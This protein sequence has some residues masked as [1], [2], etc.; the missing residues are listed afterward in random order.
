MPVKTLNTLFM[1]NV[2]HDPAK[3]TDYSDREIHTP[4]RIRRGF[5]FRVGPLGHKSWVARLKYKDGPKKGYV[6]EKKIGEFPQVGLAEARSLFDEWKYFGIPEAKP[7]VNQLCDRFIAEWSKPRKRT[8]QEDE[9]QLDNEVWKAQ[10]PLPHRLFR[11]DRIDQQRRAF[12]HTPC[13]TA[14]A[15]S[16][17]FAAERFSI[18]QRSV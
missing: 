14:R 7:T 18:Q 9:R 16:T 10:H 8:W 5:L 4:G 1:K 13:P 17:A 15:E 3:V 11:Q 12:S 2:K 6:Y